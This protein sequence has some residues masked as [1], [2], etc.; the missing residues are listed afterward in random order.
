MWLSVGKSRRAL[1]RVVMLAGSS[2]GGA[3]TNSLNVLPHAL[4]MVITDRCSNGCLFCYNGKNLS[5]RHDLSLVQWKQLI[6]ELLSW[7]P[8][9]KVYVIGGEP[10]EYPDIASLIDYLTGCNLQV[11]VFSG[12][13]DE[14][15]GGVFSAIMAKI[16]GATVS[17]HGLEAVIGERTFRRQQAMVVRVAETLASLGGRN[18][19]VNTTVSRLHTGRLLSI[20]ETVG[21]LIGRSPE[22]RTIE[23]AKG[24]SSRQFVCYPASKDG[25]SDIWHQFGW[26][27]SAGRMETSEAKLGWHRSEMADIFSPEELPLLARQDYLAEDGN[28]L[29][30]SVNG[31]PCS[32]DAGSNEGAAGID[33]VTL[34]FDGHMVPCHINCQYS[35]GNALTT[36]TRLLWEQGYQLFRDPARV[37]VES[38]SRCLGL[39]S[40][41]NCVAAVQTGLGLMSEGELIAKVSDHDRHP[42]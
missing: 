17:F 11:H 26:P 18:I 23:T 15:L 5:G 32:V 31:F 34:R 6:S 36:S 27:F 3:L 40:R 1:L 2:W 28:A 38:V 7:A 20:V 8:I 19:M 12:G 37:N 10:L 4:Y 42:A 25:Q 41:R 9:K 35:Y 33:R 24:R 16:S 22:F 29:W 14:A 13:C 21:A 39:K 30:N